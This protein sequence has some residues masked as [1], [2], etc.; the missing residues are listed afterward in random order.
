[1]I[2]GMSSKIS[3]QSGGPDPQ[4]EAVETV[5]EHRVPR[6]KTDGRPTV[7]CLLQAMRRD[8]AWTIR[9][10]RQLPP[11]KGY[12]ILCP[13]SGPEPLTGDLQHYGECIWESIHQSFSGKIHG[14]YLC[15]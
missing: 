14:H 13:I 15:N 12:M 1:M 3:G 6:G 9:G 7:G 8:H 5:I 2:I 11:V 10:L 4:S